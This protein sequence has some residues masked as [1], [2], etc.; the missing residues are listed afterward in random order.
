MGEAKRRAA[1]PPTVV[2]HH[3]STLRTNLI[4]MSGVIDV[5]GRSPGALHPLMGEVRSDL[6]Q[7]RPCRDFPPLAWFTSDIRIPGC[8]VASKMMVQ[9]KAGGEMQDAATMVGADPVQMAHGMALNRVA[10]GFPIEGSTIL[11]WKD[12]PG[13]ATREGQ[14]L[15]ESARDAGDDPTRW[16]VSAEPVD[17]MTASEIWTSGSIFQPKLV[18]QPGYLADVHRMVNLCRSTPGAY[19]PPTWIDDPVVMQ[20]VDKSKRADLLADL[21][22]QAE[23]RQS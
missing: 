6:A 14:D 23:I 8:L 3:T 19:I 17:V 22:A 4:W 2:Y 15:N 1:M 9:P 7:R 20:M 5:E 11:R 18:R 21:K 13:Y 16:Y 12:H 10:L